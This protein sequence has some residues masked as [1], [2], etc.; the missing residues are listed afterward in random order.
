MTTL[1]ITVR[2]QSDALNRI[3]DAVSAGR[4]FKSTSADINANVNARIPA[5]LPYWSKQY[6]HGYAD[7]LRDAFYRSDLEFRYQMPDGQWINA[8]DLDYKTWCPASNTPSGH[9]W[10]GSDRPYF[11]HNA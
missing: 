7:A 5:S 4:I 8:K 1:D 6:L 9:F 11:T 2:K 10:I 3:K